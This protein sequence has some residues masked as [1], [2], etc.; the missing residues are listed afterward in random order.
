MYSD[1][2]LGMV[3]PFMAD[4]WNGSAACGTV[5]SITVKFVDRGAQMVDPREAKT[6]CIE[7]PGQS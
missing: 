5:G 3:R 1:P 6:V 2:A 7:V 4:E